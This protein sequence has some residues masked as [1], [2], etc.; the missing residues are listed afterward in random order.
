[1]KCTVCG[2][3]YPSTYYFVDSPTVCNECYKKQSPE[4]QAEIQQQVAQSN[5]V[6][7]NTSNES[8]SGSIVTLKVFA[9]FDLVA[10]IIGGFWIFSTYGSTI[11]TRGSGLYSYPETVANPVGIA[12]GIG[13]ILQ[14]LF[15]CAFF[16]VVASIAENLIAIRKN[17][18]AK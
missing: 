11:V 15:A 18:I 10:G 13:I 4:K 5:A 16:L 14:G 3:D 6:T 9:W 12:I 8:G 2:T 1:M 17:T 7:V